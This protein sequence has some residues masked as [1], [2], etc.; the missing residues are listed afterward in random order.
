MYAL[1]ISGSVLGTNPFGSIS[2]DTPTVPTSKMF[3]ITSKS[4]LSNAASTDVAVDN[5]VFCT[6][7]VWYRVPLVSPTTTFAAS[8]LTY[9]IAFVVVVN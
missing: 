2:S 7:P 1:S 5:D 4:V 3:S 8:S 6:T 9:S